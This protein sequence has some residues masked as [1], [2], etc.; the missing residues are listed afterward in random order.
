VVAGIYP[1][2]EEAMTAMGGGFD[3]EYYPNTGLTAIYSKRYEQYQDLGE[4]V[5]GQIA[6]TAT[7][8]L[9]NS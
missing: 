9:Q 7:A 3:E 4:F 1:T 8:E 6:K 5:A 2:V